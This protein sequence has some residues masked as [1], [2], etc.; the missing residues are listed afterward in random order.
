MYCNHEPFLLSEGEFLKLVIGKTRSKNQPRYL[1]WSP[2]EEIH[3]GFDSSIKTHQS[4]RLRCYGIATYS[5]LLFQLDF[6]IVKLFW[7]A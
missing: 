2:T 6:I 7:S 1:R 4:K 5:V 3:S